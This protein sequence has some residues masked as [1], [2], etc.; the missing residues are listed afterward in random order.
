MSVSQE[1]AKE[2]L[3]SL[4][5]NAV[6]INNWISRT[7]NLLSSKSK[8]KLRRASWLAV[9]ANYFADVINFPKDEDSIYAGLVKFI[10]KST[11]LSTDQVSDIF[12]RTAVYEPSS[13]TVPKIFIADGHVSIGQLRYSVPS[14]MINRRD[15]KFIATLLR[16]SPL[17]TETGYFLSIEPRLYDVLSK[18]PIRTLECFASPFN[19]NLK[20][21]CSVF[22]EDMDMEYPEDV[23]CYGNFF[24]YIDLLKK[25][26]EPCRLIVNPPYTDRILNKV[27]EKIVEYFEVH[28]KAELFCVLPDWT[29]QPGIEAIMNIKGSVS[30]HYS[31]AETSDDVFTMYSFSQNRSI[32]M[33]EKRLIVI[34]N[35]QMDTSK[36]QDVLRIINT[37]MKTNITSKM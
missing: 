18:S 10:C 1:V 33:K 11:Q 3:I 34:S 5:I 24:S 6:D 13:E 8:K 19:Y 15:D 22:P 4:Y 27:G 16:Y 12:N 21:F 14:K 17:N 20:N 28:P 2:N 7:Y 29:P 25:E 9:V 37:T 26:K 32:H 31:L 23:R 30:T 35:F 36:S